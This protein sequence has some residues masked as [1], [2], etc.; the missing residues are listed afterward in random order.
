MA[1]NDKITP[2]ALLIANNLKGIK[3]STKSTY[4]LT[5]KTASKY[6]NVYTNAVD[7]LASIYAKE[8]KVADFNAD[9]NKRLIDGEPQKDPFAVVQSFHYKN[10]GTIIAFSEIEWNELQITI[11]KAFNNIY[12]FDLASFAG[13]YTPSEETYYQ[14]L[15]GV[16]SGSSTAT[17]TLYD[18]NGGPLGT[19]P[20]GTDFANAWNTLKISVDAG[21]GVETPYIA[22][23]YKPASGTN[24][25]YRF[26]GKRRWNVSPSAPFEGYDLY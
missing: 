26:T 9:W 20:Q 13:V 25:Y 8:I 11:S 18:A 14:D 15:M 4:K 6:E 17:L 7:F 19:F 1:A 12:P 23:I 10:V 22:P 16:F 5:P 21:L 3:Y 24:Y 2:T